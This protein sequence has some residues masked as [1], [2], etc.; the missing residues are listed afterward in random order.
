M[1]ANSAIATVTKP[2]I[3]SRESSEEYSGACTRP[4]HPAAVSHGAAREGSLRAASR[5]VVILCVWVS[6]RGGR[7]SSQMKRGARG[8]TCPRSNAPDA[9]RGAVALTHRGVA[10]TPSIP[11]AARAPVQ[12]PAGKDTFLRKGGRRLRPPGTDNHCVSRPR[13]TCH[14]GGGVST[15]PSPPP[16]SQHASAGV[17]PAVPFSPDAQRNDA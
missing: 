9:R 6:L 3:A 15:K 11:C 10:Y 7:R 13:C 8:P 14:A 4:H 16:H 17:Y 1:S 2:V 12:N 5:T